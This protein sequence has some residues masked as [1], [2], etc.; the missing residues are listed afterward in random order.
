M[1][2]QG[3]RIL[4]TGAAGGL[5]TAATKALTQRGA[6]VV[7]IDKRP[8]VA[9]ATDGIIVADVRKS[10]EVNAAV[11]EAITRLGGLDILINNAGVLSLQDAGIQPGSDTTESLEVNLLGPWRVMAAALPA[12]L[13]SRGRIINITSL[14]AVVNAPFIPAY[15][16]SKRALSAYSDVL[17]MQY[18]NRLTVTTIYPG[19]MNTPIHEA[20]LEQGLSV[21]RIVTFIVGGRPVLSLEE[22]LESAARGI[23]RACTGR[24][25]R[26]RGAT[27]LGTVTLIMARHVPKFV[28]AFVNWRI[29]R[30][31]NAGA[32]RISLR[33]TSDATVGQK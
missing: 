16:A 30:L 1:N 15:C 20:A 27:F 23:V 4:I 14:F 29:A 3:K 10:G 24:P 19:Y 31:V 21:A 13:A 17:R 26:D 11:S 2:L 33:T 18:G 6:R 8:S 25:M 12:L 22:P 28:D 7:G 5:G 9:S 32:L